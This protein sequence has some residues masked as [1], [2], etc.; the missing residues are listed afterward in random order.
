MSDVVLEVRGH[1]AALSG[2]VSLHLAEQHQVTLVGE[3]GRFG[4][5]VV[6]DV[7]PVADPAPFI[8]FYAHELIGAHVLVRGPG[9]SI[10]VGGNRLT[11]VD[12]TACDSLRIA[13]S[14]ETPAPVLALQAAGDFLLAVCGDP[15]SGRRWVLVVDRTFELT[16]RLQEELDV[17]DDGGWIAG[18][19]SGLPVFAYADGA[20]V[21]LRDLSA[22]FAERMRLGGAAAEGTRAA[23]LD[24]VAL[25]RPSTG[26]QLER[27]RYL[28]LAKDHG[29]LAAVFE[30]RA[31]FTDPGIRLPEAQD[32]ISDRFTQIGAV[33]LEDAEVPL[34]LTTQPA[35]LFSG[36]STTSP[37]P[38]TPEF[39]G[40]VELPDG[41]WMLT[42]GYD[43]PN[44]DIVLLPAGVDNSLGAY[45]GQPEQFFTGR[46][47]AAVS[48]IVAASQ[49]AV[50]WTLDGSAVAADY[51]QA[52][53]AAADPR[54][55]LIYVPRE[56]RPVQDV[57]AVA[58]PW[59]DPRP[60]ASYDTRDGQPSNMVRD[61]SEPNEDVPGMSRWWGRL[62]T[63]R[64]AGGWL[65]VHG[66]AGYVT[67]V[68]H[69]P[70][71]R[72]LS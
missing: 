4:A 61:T 22:P 46:V 72:E 41:R 47:Y 5:S 35:V 38:I 70:F 68:Y 57:F 20:D 53:T 45:V 16:V 15:T 51:S 31:L 67:R 54:D 32:L 39:D 26:G 17:Q 33:G 18:D 1:L 44:T 66:E 58:E 6:L 69:P 24:L 29:G 7:D 52:L 36:G 2:E 62:A 14:L 43:N 13:A 23:W 50:S 8:A 9:E 63:G 48:I 60:V 59:E 19:A 37:D 12:A 11:L 28:V 10:A 65:M 30:H 55:R 25:E 71:V 27:L 64:I 34:S 56:T 40:A 21:V 3:L 49:P 42:W